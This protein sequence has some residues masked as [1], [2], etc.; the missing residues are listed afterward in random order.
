MQSQVG[1]GARRYL[2][3]YSLVQLRCLATASRFV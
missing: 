1:Y 2:M 3:L